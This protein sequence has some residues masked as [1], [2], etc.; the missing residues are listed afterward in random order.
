MSDQ[1]D[2]LSSWLTPLIT[3]LEPTERS[4]LARSLAQ[5][6]RRSQ[7]HRLARQAGG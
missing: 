1:L 7:Q 6:L 3:R 5:K 2:D 4:K